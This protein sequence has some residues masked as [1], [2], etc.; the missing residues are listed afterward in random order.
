MNGIKLI[1]L[2]LNFI[3]IG[4]IAKCFFGSASYA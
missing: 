1:N 4:S 2:I 3:K